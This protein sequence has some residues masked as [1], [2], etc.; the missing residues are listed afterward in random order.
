MILVMTLLKKPKIL[1]HGSGTWNEDPLKVYPDNNIDP[2]NIGGDVGIC[3]DGD[4]I[5]TASRDIKIKMVNDYVY[6]FVLNLHITIPKIVKKEISGFH[7]I[8]DP[9]SL[10]FI[11]RGPNVEVIFKSTH[12]NFVPW[13]EIYVTIED[14][15][16][17]VQTATKSLIDQ[18]LSIN[19]K[20]INSNEIKDLIRH[21]KGTQRILADYRKTMVKKKN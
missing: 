19:P 3:D 6:F 20:L 7:F 10:I 15:I 21:Y 1:I 16:G 17:A 13:K 8:D 14:W 5:L 9:H 4:T 12:P 2:F 18:L 11:P